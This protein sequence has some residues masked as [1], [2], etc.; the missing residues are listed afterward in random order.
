MLM[1]LAAMVVESWVEGSGVV[2]VEAVDDLVVEGLVEGVEVV[3]VE[4]I[5]CA[6]VAD[7]LVQGVEV[8][9]K[10]MCVE[11]LNNYYFD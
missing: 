9:G 8:D 11:E 7:E 3:G 10:E 4:M 5:A 6:V 1:L 2:S